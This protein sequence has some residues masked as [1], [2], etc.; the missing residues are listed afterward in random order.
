MTL[1]ITELLVSDHRR[2]GALLTSAHKG[3]REA[4]ESLRARLLRHIALEEKIILP[5]LRAQGADVT[6]LATQLRLDHSAIAALLVP[7]PTPA[8]LGQLEALLVLHDPLEE[9]PD[10][11]Y[12]LAD[13]RLPDIPAIVARLEAYPAPP[14]AAHFSGPAAYA[15]IDRLMARARAARGLT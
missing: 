1:P 9:G 7:P 12:A 4:Y 11:L 14:L 6:A 3:D 2:M 5:A 10:G 13:Q 8:L 15:A